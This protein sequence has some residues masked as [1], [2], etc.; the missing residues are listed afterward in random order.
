MQARKENR[1][2]TMPIP[3][4]LLSLSAPMALSMLVQALYN[5]VDSIYVSRVN[6]A[7]LT[8]LSL[9][10]PVQNLM[11][12]VVS[13]FGVG[14]NALLSRSLGAKDYDRANRAA[15]NGLFLCLIGWLIFIVFSVVGVEL[16]ISAQTADPL[17]R[18]YSI[19]YLRIV[20][21]MS[22]S[23]YG[24]VMLERL[25]QA[26]G[27]SFFSMITQMTGAITNIILD[28]I[29]IFGWLGLPAMG[30]KGAA[31]ATIIGQLLA[32]GL[33]LFFNLKFNHDIQLRLKNIL[34]HGET[35]R[36]ILRVGIP[37]TIMQS[38]GSVM[39]FSMNKILI[40][41]SSTAV[42]VFGVYFKLQSFVIMPTVGINGGMVPIIAYNYGARKP[43][44]IMKT[45]KMGI[46]SAMVMMC[47]GTALFQLIPELLLSLFDASGDM[48]TMGVSALRIISWHFPIA[49]FCIITGSM[50]QAMGDSVYSMY[51][52][53][54]RQLV[55]LVPVA[56]L[57]SLTG[58]VNMVWW[59]MFIAEFMSL[60]CSVY[61][62]KRVYRKRVAP[63]M[64]SAEK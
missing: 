38:I 13:G 37:S 20:C 4:L 17:I 61:F 16:F 21:V 12:A 11:L 3:K 48:L 9:A 52:S 64:E 31:I 44:R 22:I 46:I 24:Q 63:L 2:G 54:M 43:D 18:Q 23:L 56:W 32:T 19:D 39:T 40:G 15:G 27:R 1:M 33:A 41:F 50:F 45:L 47:C 7:A 53:F 42:A 49:A 36:E 26:T 6:E 34:P 8:A 10:F 28:P 58:N 60:I 14:V 59:S 35:I 62:L 5:I 57:L 29:F 25:L 51:I 55:V 30:V